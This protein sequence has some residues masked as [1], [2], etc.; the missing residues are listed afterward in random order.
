MSDEPNAL[1]GLRVI[2]ASG[3]LA[4]YAARLLGDLGAEVIRVEPPTGS[5]V[6]MRSPLVSEPYGRGTSAFDLFVN[7]GKLSVTLDLGHADGRSLLV[8]LAEQADI[9]LETFEPEWADAVG[10][11]PSEL[12]RVNPRLIHVSVTPF[13]RSLSAAANDDD[14]TILAAGGLLHLGGYRDAE[15]VAAYGGQ[16]RFAASLFAT[17]AALIG[18]LDRERTGQ[19]RWV[20]VSAQECVAQALEDSVAT[21]DLTGEVRERL[22]SEPREAGSGI[23]R[24]A[25]GYV[26]MVAGRLG[27]A[28]AWQSLIDWLVKEEVDGATE[29]LDPWWSQLPNRQSERGISRFGE[30]FGRFTAGRPRADLYAEAQRRGIALSPVNDVAAVLADAQLAKRGFWVLVDDPQAGRTMTYPGPPYRLSAT[31][32]RAARPAPRPGEHNVAVLRDRLG[33]TSD[34][35]EQ[36]L[37]AGVV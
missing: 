11:S 29:L 5:P 37:E 4:A 25:D 10:L 27:T 23:Y 20:D 17:T 33:L 7:A 24:C 9:L 14:L 13:G 16:S 1:A 34:Q 21:Y 35:Y 18:V 26:A 28:R 32:A 12:R 6:R 3:E 15:P 19:G 8:R 22:G 30:V 31:P 2:D 36:L